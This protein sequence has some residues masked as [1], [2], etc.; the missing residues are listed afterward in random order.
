MYVPSSEINALV[1]YLKAAFE[2]E[3]G[4]SA[5]CPRV[6]ALL[7][8]IPSEFLWPVLDELTDEDG[9]WSLFDLASLVQDELR[10]R[11]WLG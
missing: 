7:R 2:Q 8:T 5:S 3:G 6:K 11:A 9:P 1:R 4:E 10:F